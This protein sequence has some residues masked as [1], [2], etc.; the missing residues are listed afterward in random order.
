[1]L[2]IFMQKIIFIPALFLE[3][4]QRYYKLIILGTLGMFGHTHQKQ[5]HQQVEN[6]YVYLQTKSQLDPSMFFTD[7]TLYRVLQSA[8]GQEHFGKKL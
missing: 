5:W 6:F 2:L 8:I 1:M 7:I 3:I 4:L